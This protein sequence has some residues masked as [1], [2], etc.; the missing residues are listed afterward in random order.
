MDRSA[1]SRVT[2][3]DVAR[4]AEVSPKTVSRVIRGNDYVSKETM[5]RVQEVILRLGYRPNRAA[6]SLVS[7][8]TG[9]IGVVIPNV[10]NPFFSEVVRGIEDAAIERDYNMLLFSTA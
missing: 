7:K 8:R 2:I 1:H 9:V 5:D 3:V 6:R 10:N 4:E